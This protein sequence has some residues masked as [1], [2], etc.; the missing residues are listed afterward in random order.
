VDEPAR[1]ELQRL[2]HA[3]AAATGDHT[4]PGLEAGAL[5]RVTPQA[6]LTRW[7]DSGGMSLSGWP[8]GPP[9]APGP[10]VASR[11][12]AAGAVFSE[13]SERRGY[14]V[15]VDAPA[16]LGERAALRGLDR[17]GNISAGGGC[18]LLA[19]RDGWVAVSLNRP[20]DWE[21]LPAL[22]RT[23]VTGWPG[24]ETAVGTACVADL[25]AR[26]GELGLAVGVLPAG[27]QPEDEQYRS[28]RSD[29]PWIIT[30]GAQSSRPPGALRAVDL[31]ALW[32]GP[33]CAS[34]LRHAGLDVTTVESTS[35]P[36]GAR[37]G[38]PLLHRLLHA[39]HTMRS[40]DPSSADGLDALHDLVMNADVVVTSARPRALQQLGLDPFTWLDRKPGLT[41]VAITAYGLTGPWCNRIGYGDDCAVAGGLVIREATP[42]FCS[43]AAADPVAGIY[44]AVAALA[45]AASGGGVVDVALRDVAA[46]VARPPSG[47]TPT[48]TTAD[49]LVI[50][51][52]RARAMP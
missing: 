48:P 15:D 45:V 16:L 42:M 14:P 38:D 11:L 44:A 22:F 36:D 39:G 52:P 2:L 41:W 17:Q 21:L 35:R 3:L 23:A 10:P 25:S 18:R 32:A 8:D 29:G 1:E 27:A 20:D 30:A 28:R 7:A 26:A 47:P 6:D 46:H 4:V 51:P 24:V 34:L 13:L 12:A 31:S 49:R 33:L 5:A 50:R 43:D 9:M 19:A 37:R 40:V